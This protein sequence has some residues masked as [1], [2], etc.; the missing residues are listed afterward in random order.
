MPPESKR[1]LM[2]LVDSSIAMMPLP[3][4][5]M[6]RAISGSWSMLMS[7]DP[8]GRSGVD[9]YKPPACRS[10]LRALL[11]ELHALHLAQLVHA[12]VELHPRRHVAP[13]R[14]V[15]LAGERDR[16]VGEDRVA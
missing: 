11:P 7:A 1:F 13:E 2:V 15:A 9:D 8:C 6:A 4:A 3:G 12:V 14:V 16:E 5:T 10:A